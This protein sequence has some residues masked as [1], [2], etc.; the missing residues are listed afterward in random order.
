MHKKDIGL[1]RGY[2]KILCLVLI[3]ALI[4]PNGVFAAGH[5]E[6]DRDV[7]LRIDYRPGGNPISNVSFSLYKVAD[8]SVNLDFTLTD[9]FQGYSVSLEDLDSAGWRRLAN[10]LGAYVARDNIAKLDKGKTNEKGQ[11]VFPQKGK[12]LK[13]GLYLVIG[14]RASRG[15][16]TYSPEPFLVSLPNLD[17]MDQW[18]YNVTV[19][20]KYDSN[21]HPPGGGDRKI[22]RKVLKIWDDKEGK[23][24]RPE[25][26]T[27]ELL[28]DG[29][30]F[31]IV[32]LTEGNGW[33]YT[34]KDLD[35]S[36]RW[37]IVEKDVPKGYAVSIS[38]ENTTFVITNSYR[39]EKPGK[40]EEPDKPEEPEK[41]EEPEE[42]G[43]P[44]EP[45]KP[46]LPK[47][48]QTGMLWWPVSALAGSGIVLLLL[49]WARNSKDKEDENE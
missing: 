43:K 39:P 27:V 2:V 34:W 22:D 21:Y 26:I 47:L 35:G 4:I 49:G 46:G 29:K 15:N 17:T 24:N 33:R 10:T 37:Q 18:E 9:A 12:S 48:P 3:I 7:S 11:L 38:Q 41:S 42:P 1:Y 16:Y 14:E 8:M 32:K 6:L 40:P 31:D 44:I 25:E 5:V 28:R 20:P 45:A 30:V 36:Y 19:L 13:P 23:E